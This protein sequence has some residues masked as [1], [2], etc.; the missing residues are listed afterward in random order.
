MSLKFFFHGVILT[1]YCLVHW[2][3]EL[4]YEG[5]VVETHCNLTGGWANFHLLSFSFVLNVR[6]LF[7]SREFCHFWKK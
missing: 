1:L 3:I 6:N 7:F 5:V 4:S 2:L